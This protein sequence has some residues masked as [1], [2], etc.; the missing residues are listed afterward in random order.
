MH[1]LRYLVCVLVLLAGSA[2]AQQGK[3]REGT[4]G[5]GRAGSGPTLTRE[6]LRECL[7]EQD[8]L[9]SSRDMLARDTQ[10][11][12]AEKA[13][14]ASAGT[15]LTDEEGKLDKT[16]AEALKAHIE[17]VQAHD[18]RIDAWNAKLPAFNERVR[19][20][21]DRND[22]WKGRCAERRY[23]EDDLILLQARKQVPADAK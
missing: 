2:T 9:K 21:T 6:Q 17:K 1:P 11:I 5:G 15:A 22:T 7:V 18:Q 12:D 4:I 23:R 20:L 14:I 19:A 16:S 3:P 8:Q 10:T 13:E